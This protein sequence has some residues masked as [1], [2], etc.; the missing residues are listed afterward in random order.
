MK[1][2][3]IGKNI[4]ITQALNNVVTEK[5][6]KLSKY[7]NEETEAH[8]TLSVE[9]LSHI[10]EITIPFN[11]HILRAEMEG[12]DMYSI[13]DDAVAIIERQIVRFKNKLRAKHRNLHKTAFTPQFMNMADDKEEESIKIE[14]T[15]RFA[16]KPM[17][18]EEAIMQM[19]MIGHNFFVYLDAYTEEVNVIY[20]RKNGTYGLIEPILD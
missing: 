20:K 10:I 16:V 14:R 6:E 8:V 7:F 17:D 11:N 3:I 15:K 5:L 12:K 18:I 13:I 9:N 19:E 4:E 2:I 1:N